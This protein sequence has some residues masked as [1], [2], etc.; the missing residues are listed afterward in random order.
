MRTIGMIGGL[1]PEATIDYY[2]TLIRIFQ[3]ETESGDYP[4]V[5]IHCMNLK[6]LIDLLE[7]DRRDDVVPWLAE[8]IGVLRRSGADFAFI[9]A[10]TPHIVFDELK[11][12]SPLPLLSIVEETAHVVRARGLKRVGL[13]GTK[14]TMGGDFFQ[15][16]FLRVGIELVV[17]RREEREF[18]HKKIAREVNL[19]LILE[20][21]RQGLLRIAR[22][23]IDEDGIEGLILGCTE[24]PLI[25]TRDEFGIPFFN[26]TEIHVESVVRYALSD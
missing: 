19:G 23:M 6:T 13:F 25:L 2:R 20:G 26:T 22:R 3:R 14:F 24:L 4:E 15:K 8:G 7:A 10:G 11:R 1:G 17:P 16:V 21:S 12:S 5:R 9:S 18:I